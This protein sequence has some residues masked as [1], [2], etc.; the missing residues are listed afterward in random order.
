MRLRSVVALITGIALLTVGPLAAQE[1]TGRIEGRIVDAQSLAVPGVTITATGPQG[2]KTAISD[3]EGRFTV[4]FLTP[5][6]YQLRA[7]LQGFK[8]IEQT[9]IKVSLGQTVHL[10]LTLE[11][12]GITQTVEVAGVAA[13][14][15]TRSTTT[16][17]VIDSDF[18]RTVPLGRRI[19]DVSYMAPGVSN[20]GSVGRQN[21]SIS[22]GS[23]LDNQ[24]VIDGVNITNQGYGAVGSYSIFHGSLGNAV[25][26]DFFKEVQ[27][28]SGGYEAEFG[29]SMGGVV[30]VIT[31]SGS[32]DFHGSAFAYTRP[33]GLEGTWK[34]Y[35]SENGTV[36]TLSSQLHDAGAEGGGPI[37]KNRVFFFGAIDP[38]WE[39]RTFQA[40]AAFDLFND[41]GL[42]R[43]RRNV[44]YSVKGTAQLNSLHRI[45]ASFFGDPSHGEM[46]PQRASS[47][48]VS[49]TSSFSE[50]DYG[51][52]NQT[53]R[54][55]GV[56]GNHWL[57]EG[58]YARAVNELSEL[59]SV[60]QWRVRDLTV[61][62]TRI[63]G[64][65]GFYEA[66]N[67][68]LNNQ[69]TIKSTN[70]VGAHQIKYGFAYDDVEYTN[71]DQ[72]TGPTFAAPDGQMTA[73]GAI[74]SVLSDPAYGSIYRV[75]RALFNS[76]RATAQSYWNF[77]VQ[78]SWKASNRLTINPGLRYEQETLDGVQVKGFALKNNWAPRIGAAYD[79][80]GDG[81]TKIFGNWGRFY[82]R[83]PNDV[84]ARHLSAD[85]LTSRA[86]Y[87]DAA[88][89]RPIPAGVL[90]GGV[91]NHFLLQNPEAGLID[92]DAKMTY[93]NEFAVGIERE[94]MASTSFGIRYIYR[95]IGRILEDVGNAPVVYYETHTDVPVR[96]TLTNP[97]SSSPIL[98]DAQ[99]LGASFDDPLH[100]YQAIEVTLNRRFAGNWSAV[101]SYRWSRLRGNYDG[102]YRDDNG[103]SDPA[104]TSLYDFPTND[105][106]Y[107]A[108]GSQFGYQGD[109]RLLGADGILPLDR[110]H[111]FKAFGNYVWNNGLSVGL[112]LNL[113]SGKPLTPLAAH[114]NYGN[115][116]EIPT[117]P[118]ASGIQ[119][120]DG[121]KTR[122]PFESQV[123]IQ[124]SYQLRLGSN[125]NL[126]LLADIFNLF[127]ERRTL[128]YDT[129]TE[130]EF[131]EPNP[132][133]GKPVSRIVPGPQFQTPIQV[134]LGARFSF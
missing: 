10:E 65:I 86:D 83:I 123:D 116:G 132:D 133:F 56:L 36:Q 73:T 127:N 27:V 67:R 5:G 41:D 99:Y 57:V 105:P 17:A 80:T 20:S 7:E 101:T 40:P 59:P 46:G 90:A 120:I 53:V 14:I 95:D 18:V 70:L 76:G 130:L 124:V 49:D 26:F 84:A 78:D 9:D 68:S 29:Q 128:D 66:G 12:G 15:D 47:L 81:K 108:V 6:T 82:A 104:W 4:P 39:T 62:P 24:Y 23:G 122:T 30:N 43:K 115:G 114:P 88:L 1:T 106:S 77:F 64:G 42:D 31:K 85:A 50:I 110:P 21:P 38:Q 19:S 126:T 129:W 72:F 2:E 16:G 63:T 87:F 109:I 54:Y 118:R 58:S 32:N 97:N 3:A 103:Q 45:D 112:G 91:I 55:D 22:G 52:H 69:W 125:R 131:G 94:V 79:P 111:Q 98:P 60:D 35:Q 117:A 25:P 89:T 96:T 93:I 33:T 100:K 92:P 107:T 119:T 121:F 44:S 102:F 113:S 11:I 37:I 34:Q 48:L 51:G 13:P 28:K 8:A 134:R 75:V 71:R 61:S 74:I